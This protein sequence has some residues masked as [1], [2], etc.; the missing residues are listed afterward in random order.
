LIYP[1]VSNPLKSHPWRKRFTTLRRIL[2]KESAKI[3]KAPLE[4][5]FLV[6]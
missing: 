1:S 5:L 3:K 2:S 6:H 4:A